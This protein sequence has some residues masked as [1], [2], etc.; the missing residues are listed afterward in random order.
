MTDAVPAI[1][2][3][4]PFEPIRAGREALESATAV[5]DHSLAAASA[6]PEWREGVRSALGTVAEAMHKHLAE[7]DSQTKMTESVA[8]AEPQLSGAA[9]RLD[10]EHTDLAQRI[11]A[12]IKVAEDETVSPH[13]VQ[14]AGAGLVARLRSHVQHANDLLED[15][16]ESELGGSD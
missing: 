4:G 15:V 2:P 13:D 8:A 1:P 3:D 10:D 12:V 16:K 5:L 7:V 14:A 9:N 11:A 6:A